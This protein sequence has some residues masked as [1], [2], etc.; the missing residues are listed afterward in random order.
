MQKQQNGSLPQYSR[1]N[2]SVHSPIGNSI[3]ITA[4]NKTTRMPMNSGGGG[5]YTQLRQQQQH[6]G[7]GF[8]YDKSCDPLFL[9]QK[10][11]S[12]IRYHCLEPYLVEFFGMWVKVFAISMAALATSTDPNG[13]GAPNPLVTNIYTGFTA[14]FIIFILTAVGRKLSGA[15][16][17]PIVTLAMWRRGAI[18]FLATIFYW[19]AQFIGAILGGL[20]VWAFYTDDTC[21]GTTMPNDNWHIW[22]SVGYEIFATAVAL[23]VIFMSIDVDSKFAAMAIGFTFGGFLLIGGHISGAALDPFRAF[24]PTLVASAGTGCWDGHW[25]YWVGPLLGA[26]LWFI[27]DIIWQYTKCV[28]WNKSCRIV[29]PK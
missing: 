9:C 7:A 21:L 29:C 18:P 3:D 15:H 16:F 28:C 13:S 2:G 19:F 17:N 8:E 26:V 22:Q 24:G 4:R 5:G 25:V 20:T 23:Q 6:I 14:G 11:G 12:K 10:M 1:G 27:L